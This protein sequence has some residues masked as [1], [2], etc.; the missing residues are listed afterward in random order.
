MLP[1]QIAPTLSNVVVNLNV[2]SYTSKPIS[3]P[4]GWQI[5]K[6]EGKRKFKVPTYEE[7]K[8]QL[9]NAVFAKERAE[10]VQKLVNAAKLE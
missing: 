2:G 3:T 4:E 1:N 10:Y 7:S 5:L 6:V 9:I 8:Q